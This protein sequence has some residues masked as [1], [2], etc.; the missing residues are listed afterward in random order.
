MLHGPWHPIYGAGGCLIL[1]VLNRF[2]KHPV[3]EF[4]LAVILC[5]IIEYFT[6]YLM[7]MKSGGI[8]W[9][10]YTGYYLNI[11][12][13]VCA[14]GLLVFGIGGIAFVY[15]FAPLLDNIFR[16]IPKK[17][18]IAVSIILVAAFLADLI[19][20]FQNPNIGEGITYS[21]ILM[22]AGGK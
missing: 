11:N 7:D 5:G 12:G 21:G 13:R 17:I 8:K 4:G 6:A 10:D 20:S 1:I 15:V 22:D 9:W 3:L 14:E 18:A 2:R 19:Y 16:L